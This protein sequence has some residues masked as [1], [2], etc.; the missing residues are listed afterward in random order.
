[1]ERCILDIRTWMLTDTLRLNDD[2][3]I[4]FSIRLNDDKAIFI[5]SVSKDREVYK[6]ETSSLKLAAA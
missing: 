6:P 1:M 5:Q 4:F 2:K 3:A